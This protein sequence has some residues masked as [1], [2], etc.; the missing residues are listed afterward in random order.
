MSRVLA[1]LAAVAFALVVITRIA[2]L[3]ANNDPG[4]ALA[5]AIAFLSIAALL[6]V[7]GLKDLGE[8]ADQMT[9]PAPGSN[10][11]ETQQ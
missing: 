1:A 5:A 9:K 6:T 11:K 10:S 4:A 8:H 3:W 2:W 7:A